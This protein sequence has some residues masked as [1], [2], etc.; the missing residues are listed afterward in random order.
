[1]RNEGSVEDEE[2]EVEREEKV[3]SNREVLGR[4]VLAAGLQC[5]FYVQRCADLSMLWG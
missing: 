3:C 1:M 4:G 5:P 2:G